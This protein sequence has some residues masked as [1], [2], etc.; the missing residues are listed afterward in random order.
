MSEIFKATVG[1]DFFDSLE[2]RK[3]KNKSVP[4]RWWYEFP[5][6]FLCKLKSSGFTAVEGNMRIDAEHK[7]F[8]GL[9]DFKYQNKSRAIRVS[10]YVHKSMD[11]GCIDT[12]VMWRWL[13]GRDPE[14]PLKLNEQVRFEI[15]MYIES[16]T[17]YNNYVFNA[18]K[19]VNEHF[20]S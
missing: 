2:E 14:T 3:R 16:N 1:Q 18:E 4:A 7:N 20:Y 12:F 8:Y 19:N 13:D 6:F 17:V 11:L 5:E 10:N 9:C 15:T